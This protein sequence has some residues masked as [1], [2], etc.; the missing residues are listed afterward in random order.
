MSAEIIKIDQKFVRPP[1]PTGEVFY[2]NLAERTS[3]I[4]GHSQTREEFI[5]DCQTRFSS[6]VV[7]PTAVD[8]RGRIAPGWV[9]VYVGKR[10]E[11]KSFLFK[12]PGVQG[13]MKFLQ[14]D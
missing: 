2:T 1:L 10:I 4:N 9:A 5:R 6:V 12:I 11:E 3:S 8:N 13:L 7:L 14:E